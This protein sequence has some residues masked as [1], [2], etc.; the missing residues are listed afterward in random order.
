V[1]LAWICGGIVTFWVYFVLSLADLPRATRFSLRMSAP[2]MWFAP[3][4]VLLSAP[5]A[6][7]EHRR[8]RALLARQAD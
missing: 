8:H 2:A 1:T 5:L 3:A 6:A 4:I 7:A